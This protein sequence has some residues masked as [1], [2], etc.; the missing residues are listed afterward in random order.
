MVA[1]FSVHRGDEKQR[2]DKI[3][4]KSQFGAEPCDARA[5]QIRQRSYK[6]FA[7]N[8]RVFRAGHLRIQ[9]ILQDVRVKQHEQQ[10]VERHDDTK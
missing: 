4:C 5:D 1:P 3:D 10:C 6:R 9:Q 8:M 7:D 2:S